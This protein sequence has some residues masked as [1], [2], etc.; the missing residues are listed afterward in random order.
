VDSVPAEAGTPTVVPLQGTRDIRAQTQ[1]ALA[2][3]ATLGYRVAPRWGKTVWD[4]IEV[5]DCRDLF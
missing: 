2:L 1:G 3:L 4:R 5:I